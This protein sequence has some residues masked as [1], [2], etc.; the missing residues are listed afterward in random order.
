[1]MCKAAFAFLGRAARI[2]TKVFQNA[3]AVP[4]VNPSFRT[5]ETRTTISLGRPRIRPRC[6][7]RRL[8]SRAARSTRWKYPSGE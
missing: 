3:Q 7:A 6:L 5:R 1:M 4:R 2:R 8:R